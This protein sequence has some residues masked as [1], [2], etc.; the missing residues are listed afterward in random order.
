MNR[1]EQALSCSFQIA[2]LAAMETNV[3]FCLRSDFMDPFHVYPAH[4]TIHREDGSFCAFMSRRADVRGVLR[5]KLFPCKKCVASPTS[6]FENKN[7]RNCPDVEGGEF[8]CAEYSA[9]SFYA[10]K[11]RRRAPHPVLR[12]RILIN[13]REWRAQLLFKKPFILAMPF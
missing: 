8:L 1:T 13:A 9:A 2:A 5:G 10:V 6:G 7:L 11:N 12:I 4:V 3:G